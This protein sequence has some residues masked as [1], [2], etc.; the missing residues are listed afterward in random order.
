MFISKNGLLWL[1]V[2]SELY[3]ETKV[4]GNL[5]IRKSKSKVLENYCTL[6]LLKKCVRSFNLETYRK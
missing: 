5:Y 3:L 4:I 1:I 6:N 2:E